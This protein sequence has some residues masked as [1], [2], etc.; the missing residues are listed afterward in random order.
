MPWC[1]VQGLPL[2]SLNFLGRNL[3]VSETGFKYMVRKACYMA[4]LYFA[5]VRLLRRCLLQSCD[6][7]VH[8][9]RCPWAVCLMH[10][11]FLL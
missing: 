7:M 9:T 11:L 6:T 2:L 5:I 8:A 3:E 4:H 1:L 10:V